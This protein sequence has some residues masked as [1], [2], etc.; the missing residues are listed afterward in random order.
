MTFMLRSTLACRWEQFL[1]RPPVEAAQCRRCCDR[2]RGRPWRARYA[3][4]RQAGRT[5]DQAALRDS[6]LLPAPATIVGRAVFC[7]SH[8]TGLAAAALRPEERCPPPVGRV[9]DSASAARHFFV[10]TMATCMPPVNHD[11]GR[12][13]S[14]WSRRFSD[15]QN[16][17][18]SA[19]I[20][21]SVA[22]G[23]TSTRPWVRITH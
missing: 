5:D 20:I 11:A 19:I 22:K 12:Q 7:S 16:A 17:N 3:G 8:G 10:R 9:R 14:S 6:F 21:F 23:A 13:G 4:A 15:A 1:F 2:L 18:R